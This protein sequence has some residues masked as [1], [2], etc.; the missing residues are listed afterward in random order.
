MSDSELCM[1]RLDSVN[2]DVPAC[3]PIV[4]P[5]PLPP[6]SHP[7]LSESLGLLERLQTQIQDRKAA[8]EYFL[9]YQL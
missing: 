3:L 9:L 7:I 1:M 6:P 2:S 8:L 5:T 4:L